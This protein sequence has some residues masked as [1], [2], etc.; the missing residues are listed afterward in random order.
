MNP[1]PKIDQ[2]LVALVGDGDDEVRRHVA[3]C[4]RCSAQVAEL[5]EVVTVLADAH[6]SRMP[7]A[8]VEDVVAR[9]SPN[10]PEVRTWEW[11]DL[12]LYVAPTFALTVLTAIVLLFWRIGGPS[13]TPINPRAVLASA[14]LCGIV[15]MVLDIGYLRRRGRAP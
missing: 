6:G 4:P 15:A 1:C 7:D 9:L 5:S 13:A 11:Q 10:R 3:S 14:L 12:L 2:I 8:W